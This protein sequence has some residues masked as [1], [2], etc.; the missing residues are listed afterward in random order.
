MKILW[1]VAARGEAQLAIGATQLLRSR[2]IAVEFASEFPSTVRFLR[3]NAWP[4]VAIH[5]QLSPASSFDD[6]SIAQLDRDIPDPG[7]HLLAYGQARAQRHDDAARLYVEVAQQIDF[8]RKRFREQRPDVVISWQSASLSTRAPVSV[9]RALGVRTL[10]F[11]NGPS[12]S[13]SAIADIDES[14]NWS[15]LVERVAR[16]KDFHLD[17]SQRAIAEAHVREISEL[18]GRFRPRETPL[19]PSGLIRPM[20]G[21]AVKTLLGRPGERVSWQV[22]RV[23]WTQHWERVFWLMRLKAGMLPYQ[24]MQTTE[25]YVYFPMQNQADV[26]LTGRNPI[27]ADQVSLA[28]HIAVSMRPG[29]MLYVREHPNH[30]GTYDLARLKKLA[31]R[32][33]IKIVHPYESNIALIRHAAAV[34]CV[35]STA[36]WE[37]YV[38]QVP[39][40]VL[41]NPFFR[42][43]R[44][45]HGVDNLNELS[46][47]IRRAVDEGKKRYREHQDEWLWFVW[48][49][50]DTCPEGYSFGY[51]KI[52]GVIPKQDMNEN[53]RKLGLAL[54][55]RLIGDDRQGAPATAS[56]TTGGAK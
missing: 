55:D 14:E 26:K 53:G 2:G 21:R 25:S 8:W 9:A 4:V 1:I 10:I 16:T 15:S 18:H 31:C 17:E 48:A 39:T 23:Q 52:F 24:P 27:Y 30:P 3:D 6:E 56:D 11:V 29:L 40:V 12:F 42:R 51:K 44:L 28:E 20:L 38:N 43:S 36:G 19:W 32:R 5:E 50:L 22:T 47:T 33:N 49:A 37:A 13:R 46:R 54:L 45:V 7:I 34:V 35:N 41:G